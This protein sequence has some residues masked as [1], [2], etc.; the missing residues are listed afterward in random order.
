MHYTIH[1]CAAEH[2]REAGAL[3]DF[4]LSPSEIVFWEQQMQIAPERRNQILPIC[5][6]FLKLDFG[7]MSY[8]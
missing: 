3:S 1:F 8:R 2:F 6:I 5:N 7:Q 4:C